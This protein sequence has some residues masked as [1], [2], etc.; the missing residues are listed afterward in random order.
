MLS[1][2]FLCNHYITLVCVPIQGEMGVKGDKG[3]DGIPGRTGPPGKDVSRSVHMCK[4][5]YVCVCACI[6]YVCT[7]VWC[8][9]TYNVCISCVHTVGKYLFRGMKNTP[10]GLLH[11]TE[12]PPDILLTYA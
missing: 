11:T 8:A 12:C 5:E 2:D 10:E 1:C 3:S 7:C 6:L 9:Y 4:C